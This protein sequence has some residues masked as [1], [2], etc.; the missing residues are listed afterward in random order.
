MRRTRDLQLG[1]LTSAAAAVLGLS[2][3]S[4]GSVPRRCV[5]GG[6]LVVAD[7]YCDEEDRGGP[8]AGG[9]YPYRWYYGGPSGYVPTGS[10]VS[11]GSYTRPSG[12]A[13]F[14]HPTSGG[15]VRGVFGG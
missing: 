15:T 11:G 14:A 6:G 4:S 3:C 12:V 2:G 13:S 8:V 5:D 10:H 9:Y 7:R 1:L